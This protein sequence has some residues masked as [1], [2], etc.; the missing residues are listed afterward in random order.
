[1]VFAH[2]DDAPPIVFYKKILKY[3]S[4]T[5]KWWGIFCT[6]TGRLNLIRHPVS[7]VIV[8]I[9]MHEVAPS[10]VSTAVITDAMICSVHFRVSLFDINS[11]FLP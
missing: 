11:S 3:S 10:A 2:R 8:Y 5:V 9:P 7:F 1:M 4:V 6:K